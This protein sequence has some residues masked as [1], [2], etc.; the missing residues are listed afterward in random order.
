MV[1]EITPM[2]KIPVNFAKRL[3]IIYDK[4]RNILILTTTQV[5][6]RSR[7]KISMIAIEK[8]AWIKTCSKLS[9]MAALL[10]KGKWIWANGI[11]ADK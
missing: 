3:V 11:K 2:V 4:I 9:K 10:I 8:R 6:D 7:Y 5:P 1:V